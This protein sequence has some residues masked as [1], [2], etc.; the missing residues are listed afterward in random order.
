MIIKKNLT[1]YMA[2]S[3]Y[4]TKIK[5]GVYDITKGD[6]YENIEKVY[7]NRIKVLDLFMTSC[8]N[9]QR[10]KNMQMDFSAGAGLRAGGRES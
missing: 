3:G 6:T 1:K 10:V 8:Y 5:E 9:G 2:E 7:K 4:S